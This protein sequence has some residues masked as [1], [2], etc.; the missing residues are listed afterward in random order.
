MPM[1]ESNPPV[2]TGGGDDG[3]TNLLG[4]GRLA[5]DDERVGLLGDV[6]E[7]SASLGIARA[8]AE[9]GEVEELLL[10]LQRLLYRIMGDASMP[11][12]PNAIGPGDVKTID[13]A[14]E[15]WRARTEIPEE[16]VVPGESKLGAL[17][18]F[19]R[20]VVRRVE[21]GMVSVGLVQD[22][23]NALE[24]INRLSDLL[25]VAARNADGKSP[26]SKE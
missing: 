19:A 24:V 22:H 26:P 9:D 10:E 23:P 6:D 20:S 13:E 16:F 3:T 8:E 7:A 15:E 17:L 4:A 2:S 14:L 1:S 12:E 18:D 21:R 25:F 5:K 11:E